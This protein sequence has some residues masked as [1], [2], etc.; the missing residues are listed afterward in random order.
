MYGSISQQTNCLS[1]TGQSTDM[2]CLMSMASL[3]IRSTRF[4]TT[5]LF[6]IPMDQRK[7]WIPTSART[8]LFRVTDS[9][10]QDFDG[11]WQK[12]RID[13]NFSNRDIN[14]GGSCNFDPKTG[15]PD[16]NCYFYLDG[17]NNDVHSSY[18]ALTATQNV[19]HFCESLDGDYLHDSQPPTKHNLMCR[20]RTVWDVIDNGDDF[21]H[22][23]LKPMNV[24]NPP[25]TKFQVLRPEEGRFVMVLDCSG[26]M[27]QANHGT[28][29][30]K[31]LQK[32]A[33]DW[34]KYD[35]R[36]DSQVGIVSF[37]YAL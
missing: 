21:Q 9:K 34:I 29:R 16:E 32:A 27:W 5:K 19:D 37:G 15:L 18:M 14:N 36:D 20:G 31:R 28:T 3:G 23:Q 33:N 30:L 22:G 11:N 12:S 6:T 24:D 35:V 13:F 10:Q 4:S 8:S 26:S 25:D 17:D 7:S 1:K 2:G